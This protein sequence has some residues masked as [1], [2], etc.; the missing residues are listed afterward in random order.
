MPIIPEIFLALSVLI[1][2]LVG[3]FIKTKGYQLISYLSLVFLIVAQV[4]VLKNIFHFEQIF[5]G[6]FVI[7]SFGSFMK[8]L[9]LIICI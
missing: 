3:P 2:I 7:D 8:S 4:L 1:L 6:F 5:N 9:L